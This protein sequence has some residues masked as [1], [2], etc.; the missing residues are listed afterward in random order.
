MTRSQIYQLVYA[1]KSYQQHDKDSL[2]KMVIGFRENNRD[3]DITG[4]LLYDDFGIFLQLIEGDEAVINGLYERIENDTNHGQVTLLHKQYAN[5]RLFPDWRMGLQYF[6]SSL[7][8]L[9]AAAMG[10]TVPQEITSDFL[11][12]NKALFVELLLCYGQDK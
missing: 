5:Q 10:E 3:M 12:E 7:A 11:Q 9:K 4:L 6:G 1:S 2:E 8:E